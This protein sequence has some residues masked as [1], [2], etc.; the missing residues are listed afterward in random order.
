[1]NLLALARQRMSMMNGRR[2]I[3]RPG[4][5]VIEVSTEGLDFEGVEEVLLGDG[6]SEEWL[7]FVSKSTPDFMYEHWQNSYEAEQ[8][9]EEYKEKRYGGLEE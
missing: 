2:K 4:L 3:S 6:S 7:H 5:K 9:I 1:M 8:E